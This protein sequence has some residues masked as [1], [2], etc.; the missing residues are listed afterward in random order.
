MNHEGMMYGMGCLA[1]YSKCSMPRG[2][3]DYWNKRTGPGQQQRLE[4]DTAWN[5]MDRTT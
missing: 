3:G 1:S 4:R 5:M 2:S